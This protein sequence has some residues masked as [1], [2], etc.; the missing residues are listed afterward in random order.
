MAGV[1]QKK[2]RLRSKKLIGDFEKVVRKA[3]LVAHTTAVMLTPV[4]TGYV[5]SRW[6]VSIGAPIPLKKGISAGVK[7]GKSAATSM[8]V[9]QGKAKLASWDIRDSD[10]YINN[11]V[12]YSVYLDKGSSMQAP[13]G[14]TLLAVAAAKKYLAT[15]KFTDK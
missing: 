9:S 5:R 2:M 11:P 3:S 6:E 4:D 12:N 13:V 8:A 10:I 1:F 14:M 15:V 7:I